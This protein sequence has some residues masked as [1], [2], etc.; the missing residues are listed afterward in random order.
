MKNKIKMLSRKDYYWMYDDEPGN[1]PYGY[2]IDDKLA[3]VIKV[4]HTDGDDFYGLSEFIVYEEYR[5]KG[6]GTKLLQYVIGKYGKYDLI[7]NVYTKNYKAISLYKK[8]GFKITY[9]NNNPD[10]GDEFYVMIRKCNSVKGR[11][12]MTSVLNAST[13]TDTN[14]DVGVDSCLVKSDTV[15]FEE[16]VLDGASVTVTYNITGHKNPLTRKEIIDIIGSDN[17]LNDL[18]AEYKRNGKEMPTV[19]IDDINSFATEDNNRIIAE[20]TF[21]DYFDC[22]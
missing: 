13:N 16:R 19:T 18:R 1:F 2:F 14:A 8:N 3:W 22:E 20:F 10:H 9:T 7:L 4:T 11:L 6:I 12:N 21:D 5:N 17:I 15:G